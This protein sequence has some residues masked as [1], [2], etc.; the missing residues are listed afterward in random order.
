MQ[1]EELSPDEQIALVGLVRLMVRMDGELSPAE[2]L[3][4]QRLAKEI[5]AT[6]FWSAM[7]EVQA[8]EM[9]ELSKYVLRVERLEV[10]EWMYGVLVGIAAVDGIDVAESELLAW[11]MEIWG[12]ND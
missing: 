4:I 11:V 1:Y 2:V 7:T 5:G 12:L 6:R 10:R 8:M 3:A 9:D